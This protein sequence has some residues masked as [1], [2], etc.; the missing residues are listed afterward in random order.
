MFRETRP[1][2]PQSSDCLLPTPL[3]PAI[4]TGTG[5]PVRRGCGN[6]DR[7]DPLPPLPFAFWL[8]GQTGRYLAPRSARP[9]TAMEIAARMLGDDPLFH[10][11][12][13]LPTRPE[14]VGAKDSRDSN[15]RPSKAQ[16]LPAVPPDLSPRD[17]EDGVGAIV[18][19]SRVLCVRRVRRC[20]G[21]GGGA[22]Q[23]A[24]GCSSAISPSAHLYQVVAIRR[25]EWCEQLKVTNERLRL[26]IA[27]IDDEDGL[28]ACA[29]LRE[30]RLGVE[31]AAYGGRESS[32]QRAALAAGWRQG[33]GRVAAGRSCW[34]SSA[35]RRVC[36]PLFSRV[37]SSWAVSLHRSGHAVGL[38]QP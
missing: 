12:I 5:L 18:V 8:R 15:R 17:C 14:R 37:R 30:G 22:G 3:A 26:V 9:R 19:E 28:V 31:A 27:V 10:R 36:A 29:R 32:H 6:N 2:W 35:A 20:Y 33:G 23:A 38:S 7:L 25:H 21:G 11:S 24:G 1:E 13:L 4:P 34:A 16:Q